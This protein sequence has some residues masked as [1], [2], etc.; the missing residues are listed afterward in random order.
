MMLSKLQENFKIIGKPWV[1]TCLDIDSQ[2]YR[3]DS[4][5]CLDIDSQIYRFD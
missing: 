1:Q 2:I 3:F 5:T 4:Q